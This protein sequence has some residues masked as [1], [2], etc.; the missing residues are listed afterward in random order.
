MLA[1]K[2]R[3]VWVMGADEVLGPTGDYPDGKLDESDDGALQMA[4]TAEKGRVLVVFGKPIAWIGLEPKDAREMAVLL[5][6]QAE[7]AEKQNS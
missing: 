3:M 1:V 7:V 2:E 6:K 4:I 5:V